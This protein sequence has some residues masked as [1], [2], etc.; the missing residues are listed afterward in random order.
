MVAALGA[1]KNPT[2]LTYNELIKL[3]D[4][5]LAPPQNELVAQHKFLSI[6]QRENQ[7]ITEFVTSL[8]SEIG[9]CNFISPCECQVSIADVF[10]RA[11]FVRGIKDDSIREHVLRSKK[12][13]FKEIVTDAVAIESSKINSMVLSPKSNPPPIDIN[14]INHEKKRDQPFKPRSRSLNRARAQSKSRSSQIDFSELG[15]DGYCLRCGKDNHLSKECRTDKS[16]LKCS[17]CKK[18]GHVPKVCISTLLEKKSKSGITN[19]IQNVSRSSR[20]SSPSSESEYV[21]SYGVSHIV[22]IYQNIN[23]HANIDRYYA[24]VK[25]SGKQIKFEVDSGSAYTFL[26]RDKFNELNIQEPLE[27][28]SIGF[29]SYTQTVFVPDGKLIVSAEY[30]GR[31]IQDEIYVVPQG[32]AAILGRAWIRRLDIDLRKIDNGCSNIHSPSST[33]NSI[34]DISALYP[35]AFEQKIGCVPGFEISLQLRENA[36]PVYHR[37]REVPYALMDRVEEEL[38]DLE[39]AGI[40]SKVANSDWGSPLVVIPKADGSVRL[41][42][43]YK[44]GVNERLVSAHYP[45]PKID[46]ILNSLRK[47][48]YFCRMDLYKA[49]LH[50]KC[51][52]QSSKIQTITTHKGTYRMN[53][54]S[55][56]IKTAPA[57]FN[58][59][60]D[61][62]LREIPKCEYYFDDIVVHGETKEECAENLDA[63]L[64]QLQKFDLHLNQ[65]KCVFF[66]EQIDFL[67]HVVKYNAISKSPKKVAAIMEMPRPSN[68]EALRRF[69][70]MVTYYSRFIKN[71]STLTAPLRNLLKNNTRFKWT[72]KHEAAF[73]RLKQEVASD[74][75]LMPFDPQLPVQLACDASPHGVAGILSHIVNGVERPI[76]FA[77][78]SLTPAEQGYSQLDREALAIIFAV[79]HFYQYLFARP[80]SLVTDNKP[81][82]RIFHENAKIPKMTSARLQR[83]AAFLSGFN[84][85]VNFRKG[86]ENSNVDCLSRAPLKGPV[87]QTDSAIN[88]EVHQIFEASI[89]QIESSTLTYEA[90]QEA[91]RN[92]EKLSQLVQELRENRIEDTE[93]TINSGILF[94]GPR[95]V[96]PTA[97]QPAVLDE[98]HRTH[99][100]VTKMKQL[101]RRYV[102]WKSIDKDIEHL[103]RSCPE[104]ARVQNSPPKAP[105]HPWMEPEGNWQ[106][107]H[108]DYAG[109]YQNHHF[110]IMV[111]AKS[112][113]AEILPC[114]TAPTSKSTIE[115][116]EEVFA[117]FGFP[118]IMVSDNATIFTS[119][120][121]KQF[122][123][124]AGITQKFIAPGHPA[125]NGLAERNVQTLKHRLAAM[126]NETSSMRK[127]IFEIL[128]RYRATPLIN[129]KTPS[130][131]FLNRQIRIRLDALKPAIK[132]HASD[133]KI[134]ARQLDVGDRVQAR[135]YSNNKQQWRPGV[136]I[137][138]LGQL[139]YTVKLDDGYSF[140]RHI[141]QLRRSHVLPK[142]VSFARG[143]DTE[144]SNT[145]AT[146]AKPE[147]QILQDLVCLRPDVATTPAPQTP[148]RQD[149]VPPGP[150]TP[151]VPLRRSSRIRRPP[152]YLDDYVVG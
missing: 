19:Q 144:D 61:Q 77:S 73:I 58:R 45:I 147:E 150:P 110:L 152:R 49:Y 81:L 11:Q 28:T 30:K 112:K 74:T 143:E 39:T 115:L 10:L 88:K 68:I 123:S 20:T 94:R 107:I 54:L 126:E 18:T 135:Y 8:R 48:K 149:E 108:V 136:I 25:V 56:G 92:D 21:H 55:F 71:A 142:Q 125:T 9:D 133:P 86:E 67:G 31:I 53:R 47:S 132:E 99:I 72:A 2:E 75:V 131:L 57:E 62:I 137:D 113:W 84:Y 46:Q 63:C 44:I 100:G 85:T 78:R 98:L 90:L 95:V 83:Y 130:E 59:I 1:P 27:P 50:I 128:F 32:F 134:P 114:R 40:I 122:C 17:S 96:I 79:D 52:D 121:F 65:R 105:L 97:M 43:D 51:D 12:T 38:Q 111:D 87:N 118:D 6:Y 140:K 7:S 29:R 69:L 15:V 139:H 103:V 102:Y 24:H 101:A 117:R 141:D 106:R 64:R 138:K 66:E 151:R 60:M 76:A 82:V 41:C 146:T 93:F 120:E 89:N 35:Q 70:G 23:Q 3:L 104:C 4:D 16:K 37:E 22:D 14:K 145:S 124:T 148:T 13:N 127:K 129:G 91:Y 5:H 26:P 33:I 109:P 34:D 42:V 80:F 36:K 119:G 116:M